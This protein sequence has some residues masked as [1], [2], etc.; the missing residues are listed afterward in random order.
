[1]HNR[2]STT[3]ICSIL[4]L[5]VACGKANDAAVSTCDDKK[6]GKSCGSFSKCQDCVRCNSECAWC[7][8]G[9]L[10]SRFCHDRVLNPCT[11]DTCAKDASDFKCMQMQDANYALTDFESAGGVDMKVKPKTVKPGVR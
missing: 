4:L 5:L 9:G 6:R 10:C 7:V 11:D 2:H 1:M 8:I 3:L